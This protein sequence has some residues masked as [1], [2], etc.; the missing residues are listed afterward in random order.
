MYLTKWEEKA[1]QGEFGEP[2]RMAMNV[3]VK[4]CKALKGEKLI[5]I[6][7]AHVSGISYFNIGDE[8]LELLQDLAK[9]KT[10]VLVY[11]TANP[12]SIALIDEFAS[13][14]G[15]DVVVKQRKIVELLIAIGIDNKSFTC[16]PYKLRV[17]GYGEHLAWAESSAVIYANSIAGAKTNRE[18]GITALMAAIAGRTCFCGMHIDENR[19]PTE[20]I[21]VSFPV[22]S[23]ALA[24]ALGLFIG[25]VVRGIPYIKAVFRLHG[26][27]RDIAIRS[28][29]SSIASTSSTALALVEGITPGYANINLKGLEKI[30]V[31][32]DD[33]K[34]FIGGRCSDAMFLGCPHIDIKEAE[35]LLADIVGQLKGYGIKKVYIAIPSLDLHKLSELNRVIDGIDIVYLPGVC[36]V[37]SNLKLAKVYSLSTIHGKAYHYLPKLAG[38]SSCLLNIA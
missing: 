20:L 14:Y 18:G 17:P 6:T 15:V 3:L 34:D 13:V 29:L 23:I 16:V 8:G 26:D 27:I 21:E 1:L 12:S 38:A 5:E 19:C 30:S 32:I 36:P 25:K 10:R 31:D 9:K 24:S 33:V 4:V 35:E 28:M 7:H 2:L 37:V 22:N 11:T